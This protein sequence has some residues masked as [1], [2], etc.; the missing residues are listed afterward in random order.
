[1]ENQE[2]TMEKESK[3]VEGEV[4]T[5]ESQPAAGGAKSN[6]DYMAIG[7][8]ILGIIN[9]CSWILPCCGIPFGIIGLVLGILGKKSAQYEKFALVGMILSGIDILLAIGNG[10]LGVVLQN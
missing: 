7:A 6:D 5:K 1:M 8:L 2:G 3:A 10:I 4:M 9:L